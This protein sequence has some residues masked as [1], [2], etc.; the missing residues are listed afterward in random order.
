MIIPKFLLQR[1]WV[2]GSLTR[3]DAHRV[4]FQLENPFL[5][6][7]LIG[8]EALSLNTMPVDLATLQVSTDTQPAVP[9]LTL[10]VDNAVAIAHKQT[11]TFAFSWD[12]PVPVGKLVVGLTAVSKETGAMSVTLEDTLATAV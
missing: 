12:A 3:V 1:L 4:A 7:H 5:I 11:A 9:A 10:S 2:K 6:G 8:V